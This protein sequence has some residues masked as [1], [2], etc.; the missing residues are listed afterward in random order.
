VVVVTSARIHDG[1]VRSAGVRSAV[2]LAFM[3]ILALST[4]VAARAEPAPADPKPNPYPDMRY[5]DQADVAGFSI[6]GGDGVWFLAPT[7]QN[8]GIWGRGSFGCA[9]E[10]PG[11]PPGTSHIAWIDTDGDLAVRY[12]WIMALKFP[13]TQAQQ[14]LPPHQFITYQGTTCGVTLDDKIY[15][16]RGPLR[17][18][19][20][21]TRT[22]LN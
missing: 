11:A 12:D 19:I 22:W 8:C 7:G 18:V 2:V 3:V 5:F 13:P 4:A 1:V 20:E 17:F 9:G 21:P 14:P 16:E 6:P 15:C 10:I